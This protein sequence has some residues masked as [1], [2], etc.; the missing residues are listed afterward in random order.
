VFHKNG[1]NTVRI[2]YDEKSLYQLQDIGF[3]TP[4]LMYFG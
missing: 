4:G 2:S 3:L 1:S